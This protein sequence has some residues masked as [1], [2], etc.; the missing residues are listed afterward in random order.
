MANSEVVH[1]RKGG[2]GRVSGASG[3]RRATVPMTPYEQM[4]S[5]RGLE[6]GKVGRPPDAEVA[7]SLAG[8]D[9]RLADKARRRALATL[10]WRWRSELKQ[11]F[12]DEYA[13]LVR[14]QGYEDIEVVQKTRTVTRRELA[15]RDV[16]K[17]ES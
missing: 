12:E 9:R 10:I 7:F 14:E 17:E 5:D 2:A 16:F 8:K 15:G 6:P 3:R 4:M 11:A 13:S 1:E